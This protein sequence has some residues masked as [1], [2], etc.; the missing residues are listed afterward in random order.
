MGANNDT[1]VVCTCVFCFDH[2]AATPKEH[3][4]H[5]AWHVYLWDLAAVYHAHPNSKVD[6][7]NMGPTWGGQ[8]PGGPHVGP[9]N[10]AIWDIFE[11]GAI[12]FRWTW[13]HS[14]HPQGVVKQLFETAVDNMWQYLFLNKLEGHICFT[15]TKNPKIKKIE[16]HVS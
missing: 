10:F 3:V 1:A 15:S 4:F 2:A 11:A 9:M 12:W 16:T 13:F 6:G 5:R 14:V 7:A 8:D